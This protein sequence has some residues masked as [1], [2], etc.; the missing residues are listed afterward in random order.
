MPST[1]QCKRSIFFNILTH[2]NLL[3][4]SVFRASEGEGIKAKYFTYLQF[5]VLSFEYSISA[6]PDSSDWLPH[7]SDLHSI[8]RVCG[9]FDHL[10]FQAFICLFHR[11]KKKENYC[12]WWKVQLILI[13]FRS[14]AGCHCSFQRSLYL[15]GLVWA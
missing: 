1:V 9:K 8:H 14:L 11:K 6:S 5:W 10:D 3:T 2:L 4:V 7:C 13:Y 12:L 15:V